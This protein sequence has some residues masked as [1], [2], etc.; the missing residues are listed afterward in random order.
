M[1]VPVN[2]SDPAPLEARAEAAIDV[3][4]VKVSAPVPAHA[5]D[6]R[7]IAAAPKK[8]ATTPDPDDPSGEHAILA[9]P[10]NASLPALE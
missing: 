8:L 3:A 1:A 9:E 2:V 7:A 4:P 5:T 6:E 10:V